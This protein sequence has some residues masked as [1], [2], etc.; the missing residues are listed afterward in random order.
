M[1]MCVSV[2]VC[3]CVCIWLSVT[4]FSARAL[5]QDKN[6]LIIAE[7]CIFLCYVCHYGSYNCYYRVNNFAKL[8]GNFSSTQNM[9]TLCVWR[10]LHC[11]SVR[12]LTLPSVTSI[13]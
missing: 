2:S 12:I 13:S 9:T 10:I 1:C 8:T 3:V 5:I 11:Q 7:E 6:Y 4:I